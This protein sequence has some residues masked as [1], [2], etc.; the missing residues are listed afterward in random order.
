MLLTCLPTAASVTNSSAPIAAFDRPCATSASTSRSRADSRSSGFPDRRSSRPT[1]S[2]SST[3]PPARTA[4]N[5][6]TK[7]ATSAT[8]SLSR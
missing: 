8:R 1:T 3:V 7:S 4:R 6:A 2:G 5:A